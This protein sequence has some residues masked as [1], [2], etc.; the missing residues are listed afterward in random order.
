MFIDADMNF[1]FHMACLGRILE[2]LQ[3]VAKG[4]YSSFL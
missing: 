3:N 4:Y 1:L 2:L